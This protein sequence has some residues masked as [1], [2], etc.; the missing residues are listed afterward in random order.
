[1]YCDIPYKDTRKYKHNINYELFYSTV[2]A[3]SI[4]GQKIFIS[5]YNM[6]SDFKCIWSKE[7]TNSINPRITSKPTE[8]LFVHEKVYDEVMIKQNIL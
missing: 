4:Y 1:M 3:R 5:E 7:I 2:R 8:K 6:P